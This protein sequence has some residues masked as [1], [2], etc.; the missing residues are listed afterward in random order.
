MVNATGIVESWEYFF[1]PVNV[2]META[3]RFEFNYIPQ[4]EYL[5]VPFEIALGVVTP[6]GS[7]R[8]TR[9]RI[10]AQSSPH[11]PVQAGS[12]T[13]FGGFYNGTLTQW[14]N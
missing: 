9:Y 2:R 10:E 13:R 7:Y 12:T 11:R 5:A 8:F 4:Y 14:Q 1:A 3:D 6:P